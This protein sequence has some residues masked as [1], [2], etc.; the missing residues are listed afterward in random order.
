MKTIEE[1]NINVLQHSNQQHHYYYDIDN[2]F[3]EN[4]EQDLLEKGG[5]SVDVSLTKTE[6]LIELN[7]SIKGTVELYCD[8]SLE[9]FDH[10]ISINKNLILKYD[11]KNEELT[12]EI[13]TIRRDTERINIAQYIYDFIMIAIPMKKIHPKFLDEYKDTR[14]DT[15]LIYSSNNESENDSRWD[16]LQK[17]NTD[18][19]REIGA[20]TDKKIKNQF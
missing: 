5:L 19:H 15:L 11:E 14:N 13:I 3:F 20:G 18:H 17:L 12:D 6:T 10:S 16:V 4:F 8:R 1:Y 2:S 7:F 9:L